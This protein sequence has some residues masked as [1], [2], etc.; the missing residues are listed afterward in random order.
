M[1]LSKVVLTKRVGLTS[2][3]AV[4]T[5]CYNH[6]YVSEAA[7]Q[8]AVKRSNQED[9]VEDY[10]SGYT[11]LYAMPWSLPDYSFHVMLVCDDHVELWAHHYAADMNVSDTQNSLNNRLES[12]NFDSDTCEFFQ[13]QRFVQVVAGKAARKHIHVIDLMTMQQIQ[14]C[15]DATKDAKV[16]EY[17]SYGKAFLKLQTDNK[18]VVVSVDPTTTTMSC[19]SMPCC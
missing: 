11:T 18:V 19:A 7:Y 17:S 4:Q 2:L 5:L 6:D 8:N 15:H 12:L 10:L 16:V 14:V 3:Y 13:T 9:A 1:Y